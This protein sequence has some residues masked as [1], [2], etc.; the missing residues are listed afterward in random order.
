MDEEFKHY[1]SVM[2]ELSETLASDDL[3]AFNATLG[4]LSKS[5]A[6]PKS[7]PDL[8]SAR[9]I[10]YKLSELATS[11]A[12]NLHASFPEV[13]VFQ[14]PMSDTAA[15]GLPKNAKWIQ[16]SAELHNPYMGRQMLACGVEVK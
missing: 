13:K 6:S 7:A 4:K 2:A 9:K 11:K 14:C 10:F 5:G 8:A 15:E 12:P 3:P 1:I 16:F